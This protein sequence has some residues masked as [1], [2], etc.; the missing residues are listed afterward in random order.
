LKYHY[1]YARNLNKY[2]D[3]AYTGS[4]NPLGIKVELRPAIKF[5]KILEE[6]NINIISTL[7]VHLLLEIHLIIFTYG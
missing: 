6:F 3:L 5:R 1:S 2:S 7:Q 4:N